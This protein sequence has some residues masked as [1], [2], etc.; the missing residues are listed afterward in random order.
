MTHMMTTRSQAHLHRTATRTLAERLA[1]HPAD[2]DR[3]A[4]IDLCQSMVGLQYVADLRIT[5]PGHASRVLTGVDT[6]ASGH[7]IEK[8]VGDVAGE[9]LQPGLPGKFPDYRSRGANRAY[10][11]KSFSRAKGANFDVAQFASVPDKYKSRTEALDQ[12]TATYL[13]FSYSIDEAGVARI[14]GFASGPVWAIVGTDCGRP[15]RPLN[16]HVKNNRWHA[17]RPMGARRLMD[18]SPKITPDDWV[19]R[20]CAMQRIYP[21]QLAEDSTRT[22]AETAAERAA[23]R[24]ERAQIAA[25][26]QENCAA[27]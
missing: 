26:I 2:P 21:V 12:L 27:I 20:L 7:H 25:A 18:G 16:V 1:A 4:I 22:D 15:S 6:N 17:L 9:L 14:T 24:E 19:A 23:K 11:V 3:A 5:W 13:V 8:I 10:E